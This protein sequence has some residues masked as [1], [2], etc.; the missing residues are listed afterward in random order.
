MYGPSDGYVGATLKMGNN[1]IE[2]QTLESEIDREL[3]TQDISIRR[4]VL[5]P[6][7]GHDEYSLKANISAI[8][9]VADEYHIADLAYTLSVRRSKFL[10]RA[11]AITTAGSS[12]ASLEESTMTFAK[13]S[14]SPQSVGYIFTGQGAQWPR[15]GAELLEEFE[16]CRRCIRSMD[17]ILSKLPEPPDW[18]IESALLEPSETSRIKEPEFSQPLCTALQI[19]IVDLLSS[20]NVK[21]VATV[22][23]SSG[24]IAAAYAAGVHTAEEAIVMAYYRGQ[25]LASHTIQG[26]ML[27]VGLGPDG[28]LPYIKEVETKVVIAAINSPSSV[29]LS[30]DEEFVLKVKQA[31]DQDKV[32]ARLLQTGGK[33]Y[34]SHHMAILGETYESLAQ[35]AVHTLSSEI[36]GGRRQDTA[37]WVSSVVPSQTQTSQSIGPAYWRKNL[38]SPVLFGPAVERV[39]NLPEIN[40]DIWVEIGPHAALA[41][42]LRQIRATI[43]QR[44]G[45]KLP[46]YLPS[47]TRAEDGF[48]N[49]LS[50]A[51]NLFIRNV[52]VNL[53]KVNVVEI[54][55]DK[56]VPHTASGMI[57]GDLPNYQFHYGTPLYHE[58][59]YNKEWRL[60]KH[61]RHDILGA[62]QPGCAKERPSWRNM[63][64]MKDVPWLDDHKVGLS[65][66]RHEFMQT[67]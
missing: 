18:T 61:L 59:R 29:T 63:L 20:W 46:T 28:V 58:S 32:F 49:M 4:L 55:D 53:G 48:K 24:E 52:P 51:G 50:L 31:L 23:H 6:F 27:A 60:R 66:R 37:T 12:A 8:V 34:H 40:L 33:A 36:A 39:A 2:T 64:R 3:S 21:P 57:I 15:M 13:C 10:Q 54:V 45:V 38:E 1:P 56:A 65:L 30:G 9:E 22:G 11:F 16:Q 41:G 44:H 67:G 14:A 43:E 25:V 19:A 42:P 35:N 62:R 5:L 7:S 47:I 26:R 17:A